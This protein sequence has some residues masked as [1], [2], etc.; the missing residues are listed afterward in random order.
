MLKLV[1]IAILAGAILV[2]DIG[3]DGI[4]TLCWNLR[5]K[6]PQWKLNYDRRRHPQR[7]HRHFR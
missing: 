7:V 5:Q 3:W 6:L 1:L 2:G 4:E